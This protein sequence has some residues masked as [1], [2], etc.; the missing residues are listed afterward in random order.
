VGLFSAFLPV[1][2]GLFKGKR[3]VAFEDS[4]LWNQLASV[5]A[6]MQFKKINS[7]FYFEY[8]WNDHKFNL[9]DMM[10]SVNHSAAFLVGAK[11]IFDLSRERALDV[12]VEYNQMS[13][14][15]DYLVRGAGAWYVHGYASHL[16]SYGEILGSGVGL[17][18][19]LFTLST[20]YR[21]GMDQFGLRFEKINR[22]PARYNSDW[23]DFSLTWSMRKKLSRFLINAQVSG[24]HSRNYG[25]MQSRN[26]F[27]A[28]ALVGVQYYW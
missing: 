3:G 14:S 10:Q 23:T 1:F 24:V 2:D 26:R 5:Y 9:R 7:E 17:G 27:N 12:S 8:G 15:P 20:V 13:E 16:S 6:R 19:D 22:Y 4:L 28:V 18:S 25:W 11:K 21:K